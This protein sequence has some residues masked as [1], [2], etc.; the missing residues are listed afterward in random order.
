MT[1]SD[2]KSALSNAFPEIAFRVFVGSYA[3]GTNETR[4]VIEVS[5]NYK[6]TNLDPALVSAV[7]PAAKVWAVGRVLS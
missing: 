7:V 2:I 5:Y 6:R 3:R 1:K 4:D